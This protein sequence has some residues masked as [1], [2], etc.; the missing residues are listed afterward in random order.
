MKYANLLALVLVVVGALN[1]A[2]YGLF[3]LDLVAEIFGDLSTLSRVVYVLVGVAG[4]YMLTSF[5]KL[6]K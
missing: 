3:E 5:E 2:L 1:W 4:V 6:T